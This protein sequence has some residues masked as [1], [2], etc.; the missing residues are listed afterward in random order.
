[1]RLRFVWSL[2]LW[3]MVAG[4][5]HAETLGESWADQKVGDTVKQLKSWRPASTAPEKGVVVEVD[6]QKALKLDS[7]QP[8]SGTFAAVARSLP[9]AGAKKLTICLEVTDDDGNN[10][11]GLFL[12]PKANAPES[13]YRYQVNAGQRLVLARKDTT[14]FARSGERDPAGR[15]TYELKWDFTGSVTVVTALFDGEVVGSFTDDSASFKPSNDATLTFSNFN[16]DG[17]VTLIHQ[18]TIVIE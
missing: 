1:M 10:W 8:K 15:H 11:F 4:P 7:G 16:D 14:E 13:V 17:G 6:G 9:L 2:L 5:L 18:V 12:S 3:A